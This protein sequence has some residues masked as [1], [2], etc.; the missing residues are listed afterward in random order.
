MSYLLRKVHKARWDPAYRDEIG[1]SAGDIPSDCIADLNTSRCALSLWQV[2]ADRSN[3]EAIAVAMATTRDVLANFEYAL[4]E[5][6]RI[7]AIGVLNQTEGDSPNARANHDWHWDLSGLSAHRLN[8]LATAMYDWGARFRII[9]R[10]IENL[11]R[12]A[13]RTQQIDRSKMNE[14][15]RIR[16]GV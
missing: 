13:V 2:H 3:V 7:A 10:D 6:D 1:L 11:V 5:Y 16:L 12:D 9:R 15:L 4:V 8:E 14:K